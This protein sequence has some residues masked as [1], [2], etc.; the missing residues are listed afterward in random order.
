MHSRKGSELR[1]TRPRASQHSNRS[2]GQDREGSGG[3]G[4]RVP[5]QTAAG[6]PQ[7]PHQ[8]PAPPRRQAAGH[9]PALGAPPREQAGPGRT[10]RF[11]PQAL[12]PGPPPRP[13]PRR[14][15]RLSRPEFQEN[16]GAPDPRPQNSGPPRPRRR[17]QGGR[18]AP[19]GAKVAPVSRAGPGR[20][21]PDSRGSRAARQHPP[22]GSRRRRGLG[23]IPSPLREPLPPGPPSPALTS[24]LRARSLRFSSSSGSGASDRQ[25]LPHSCAPQRNRTAGPALAAS[26]PTDG[27]CRTA[28]RFPLDRPAGGGSRRRA[29]SGQPPAGSPPLAG[30]R[31]T[32]CQPCLLGSRSTLRPA[33]VPRVILPDEGKAFSLSLFLKA[34]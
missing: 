5:H 9:A 4:R 32:A 24:R 17:H 18:A 27:R 26:R 1:D 10:P 34:P 19:W 13:R 33:E 22:A 25:R 21:G 30:L 12:R 11:L 29:L 7:P 28:A 31:Q 14:R 16:A 15:P 2:P 8:R 20:A 23:A 3:G 6:A